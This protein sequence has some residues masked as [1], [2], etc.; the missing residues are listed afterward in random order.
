MTPHNG[1]PTSKAIGTHG[2]DIIVI[3][4]S[5]G[6]FSPLRAVLRSLPPDLPA[7]IF[8]ALHLAVSGRPVTEVVRE[9]SPFPVIAPRD[10]HVWKEQTLYVATPNDHLMFGP[11]RVLRV[12]R[13]PRENGARPSIDALFRSAAVQFGPRVVGLLLSGRLFDGAAGLAAIERCG[14]VTIVQDPADATESELPLSAL[15]GSKV[16]HC[17]PAAEIGAKLVE[18]VHARRSASAPVPADLANEA[19]LAIS[20][21]EGNA[22]SD[23]PALTCPACDG[24]LT[25]IG[26]SGITQFRCEVGHAYNPESLL[27]E[28]GRMV[29]RALWIALRTLQERA[30]LLARMELEAQRRG[31]TSTALGFEERRLEIEENLRTI[32]RAIGI[33]TSDVSPPIAAPAVDG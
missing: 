2:H 8:V 22:P 3:G 5:S 24:P 1:E 30:V 6:C 29:E 18:L 23:T 12:L 16:H 27:L 11:E 26:G 19:R 20:A 14:G 32:R 33:V 28:Q 17:L 13:G 21:G 25:E 7:S 31:H 10:G 9:S 4:G 15:A